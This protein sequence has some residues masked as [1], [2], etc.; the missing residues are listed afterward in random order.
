LVP[1]PPATLGTRL[2]APAQVPA[3]TGVKNI[4]IRNLTP[5][6]PKKKNPVVSILVAV[7]TVAALA[8]GGYYGFE[9]YQGMQEKKSAAAK[10]EASA[11]A[12]ARAAASRPPSPAPGSPDASTTADSGSSTGAIIPPK[13]TLEIALATIPDTKVNGT[14]SG[15]NFL[16]EVARI[17][18]VGTAQV[19]R[20]VQGQPMSPDREVLVYLHLKPGEK[21]GGQSL[22]ISSDMKGAGVP[23]V[24]K[25]WKISPRYAPSLKTYSTGYVMKLELAQAGPDGAVPGKIFLALPDTEQTVVAGTFKAA[26]IQPDPTAQPAQYTAPVAA[27]PPTADRSAMDRR[28]GTRR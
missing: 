19:L 26:V 11:A 6:P 18:T 24:A 27:P 23:Q 14:I 22:A 7:V 15:T 8:V 17:D 5:P 16:A 4:P 10:A 9:W 2:A 1:K 13:H 25:R 3:Q 21:P 20:L 12:A 28:Y